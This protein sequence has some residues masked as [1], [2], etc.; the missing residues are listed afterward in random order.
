M[1]AL[2]LLNFLILSPFQPQ[3]P[4]DWVVL[5]LLILMLVLALASGGF[6]AF[7]WIKKGLRKSR[8]KSENEAKMMD[9]IT[10]LNTELYEVTKERDYL[11]GIPNAGKGG[12]GKMGKEEEEDDSK[13]FTRLPLIDIKYKDGPFKVVTPEDSRD[14][15]LAAIC[16]RFRDFACSQM[17]LFYTIDTVRE[18]FASMGASHFLILEGISGTGKTSLPYC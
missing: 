12:K 8:A 2:S 1:N 17:K 4:Y 14:L 18:F 9:E 11:A 7:F 10:R 6:L 15:D 3:T 16:T 13:R 5:V